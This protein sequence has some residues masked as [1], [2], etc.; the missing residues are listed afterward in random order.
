MKQANFADV[1]LF[2]GPTSTNHGG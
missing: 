2:L 1:N